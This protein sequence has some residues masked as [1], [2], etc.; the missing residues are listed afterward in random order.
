MQTT[1]LIPARDEGPR[2]GGTVALVRRELPGAH[3][4]VVD[5]GSADDTRSRAEAAGAEVIVQRG[6]GYAGALLT[7][8]ARLID[9]P[10]QR[11]VQLD[12]DGQHPPEAARRLLAALGDHHIV[13]ASRHR[14]G[15]GGAWARRIGNHALSCLVAALTGTRLHDVTS[16]FWAFDRV[17]LAALLRHLPRDA[18]DANVRVLALRL[19][20]RPVEVP[21]TMVERTGGRSMHDGWRGIRNFATSVHRTLEAAR[22]EARSEQAGH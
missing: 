3:V 1:V 16:G 12:A 11:V 20:L 6:T 18:A 21:V 15:T 7:G 2:I 22:V 14:T 9:S 8:Y 4:L 5:G 10:A 17:A 13:M 19:G